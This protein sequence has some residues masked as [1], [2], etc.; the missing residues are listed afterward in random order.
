MTGVAALRG[1][2]C[3]T[4][5]RLLERNGKPFRK[6]R[7]SLRWRGKGFHGV[8]HGRF[9]YHNR[10]GRVFLPEH[11]TSERNAAGDHCE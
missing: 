5:G 10:L 8:R 1:E 3:E 11:S 7:R 9:G 2:V 4:I 6:Q